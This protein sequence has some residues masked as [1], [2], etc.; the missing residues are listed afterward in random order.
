MT[1]T[2]RLFK[3]DRLAFAKCFEWASLR[4]PTLNTSIEA[5]DSLYEDYKGFSDRS[6][7]KALS[8]IYEN[9]DQYLELPKLY[10]LTKDLYNQEILDNRNALPSPT[11]ENG[12]KDY[13]KQN[14]YKNI[15]DAIRKI[16]SMSNE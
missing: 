14:N 7:T 6:L 10:R 13:L 4:W 3:M 5:L 8:L 11:V 12:L 15:K 1:K 2:E 9:G 16:R